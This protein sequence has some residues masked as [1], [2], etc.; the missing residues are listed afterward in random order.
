MFDL[1]VSFGLQIQYA[2]S[3]VYWLLV[4]KNPF[5]VSVLID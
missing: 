5:N 3:N 2:T 4:R 1:S